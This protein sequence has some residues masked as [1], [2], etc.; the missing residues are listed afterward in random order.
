MSKSQRDC[1]RMQARRRQGTTKNRQQLNKFKITALNEMRKLEEKF[2]G[3]FEP[4]DA[5][6]AMEL[7]AKD[8]GSGQLKN[9]VGEN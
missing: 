7:Q 1:R 6:S 4:Y 9:I 8:C 2:Q 5:Q 3:H